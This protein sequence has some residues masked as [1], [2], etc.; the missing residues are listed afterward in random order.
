MAMAMADA[1]PSAA[2]TG[3]DFT[4]ST[5]SAANVITSLAAPVTATHVKITATTT[6]VASE[7]KKVGL[8]ICALGTFQATYGPTEYSPR[9]REMVKE[10]RLADGTIDSTHIYRSAS[11][12]SFYEAD[13]AFRFVNSTNRDNF[14]TLRR[15][16]ES[17]LFYPFPGEEVDEIYLGR[18]KPES[19]KEPYSSEYLSAG[20]DISFTFEETGGA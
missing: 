5:N 6:I 15:L 1:F 2:F 19:Y 14:Q 4:S 13:L 11:S 18:M 12:F 20:R 16:N 3:L 9:F 7:E 10:V 8:F 17:F